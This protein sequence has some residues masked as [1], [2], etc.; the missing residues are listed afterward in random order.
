MA[1]PKLELVV[2]N[3]ITLL[4]ATRNFQAQ[5][6]KINSF[7][8]LAQTEL[9]NYLLGSI[10]SYRPG[11]PNPLVSAQV[12]SD[13]A[14][15]LAKFLIRT[16]LTDS[17]SLKPGLFFIPA[18]YDVGSISKLIDLRPTFTSGV[19]ASADLLNN[20][21]FLDRVKSY[22]KTPTEQEPVAEYYGNG[23][24][25]NPVNPIG[26]EMIAY[27]SPENV[28]IPFDPITGDFIYTNVID[29]LWPN[30]ALPYLTYL[31]ISKFGIPIN[32]P[33][34]IKIGEEL[35]KLSI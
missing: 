18:P 5:P 21:E 24:V 35:A 31:I 16:N 17:T 3:A 13:V 26:V 27:I 32:N 14:M 8:N 10:P 28:T 33:Q 30:N 29:I 11:S 22:S 19:T 15:K 1:A 2:K 7:V 23:F 25:F 20:S 4:E 6:D 34:M 12:T 9:Q